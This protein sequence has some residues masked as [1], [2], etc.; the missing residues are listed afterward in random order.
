MQAWGRR[1]E[2][3]YLHVLKIKH[4]QKCGCLIFLCTG[5]TK[6]LTFFRGEK[7]VPG[8]VSIYVG[9]HPDADGH[10]YKAKKIYEETLH[11]F[12]GAIPSVRSLR[13]I[14]TA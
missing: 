8:K 2:S 4:L 12:K 7:N 13:K 6:G 10:A 1:F 11:L 9:S 5:L 14:K 3:D